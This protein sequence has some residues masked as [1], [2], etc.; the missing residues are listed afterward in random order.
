MNVP[1]VIATLMGLR[2][3]Q[4]FEIGGWSWGRNRLLLDGGGTLQLAGNIWVNGNVLYFSGGGN[5]YIQYNGSAIGLSAAYVDCHAPFHVY[6]GATI[7]TTLNVS[8]QAAFGNSI[9]CY[10]SGIQYPS[11]Q[12][13]HWFG[14]GWNGHLNCYVDGG[15]QGDIQ[16]PSDARL[17]QDIAPS[18]LDA[19]ATICEIPLFEFRWKDLTEP[20]RLRPAPPNAPLV[21]VGFVA[22]NLHEVFAAGAYQGGDPR[23]RDD[24]RKLWMVDTNVMLAA[25][26]GAVQQLAGEVAELKARVH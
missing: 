25:L 8:G 23:S 11:L 2:S 5:S 14:F 10:G 16:G 3:D 7:D 18:R 12:S 24:A 21:P 9:I 17:K 20:S 26:C 15:Y 6:A 19:L 22:Q 13:G 4:L 1:N